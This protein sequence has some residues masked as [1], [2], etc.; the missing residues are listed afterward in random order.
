LLNQ[1]QNTIPANKFRLSDSIDFI[2]PRQNCRGVY[3]F[4]L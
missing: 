3:F 4:M 2:Q 1:Y